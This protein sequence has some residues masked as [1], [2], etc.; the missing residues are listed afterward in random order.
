METFQKFLFWLEDNYFI[1]EINEVHV[2][3]PLTSL[4]N[5]F[6]SCDLQDRSWDIHILKAIFSIFSTFW[7]LH[8]MKFELSTWFWLKIA[9]SPPAMPCYLIDENFRIFNCIGHKRVKKN[10]SDG[11]FN[12]FATDEVFAMIYFYET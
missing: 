9:R 4:V 3:F 7:R 8:T 2:L 12:A 11:G 1:C 6:M 5:S 10:V